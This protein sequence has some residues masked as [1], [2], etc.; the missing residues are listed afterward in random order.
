MIGKVELDIA[1]SQDFE[2]LIVEMDVGDQFRL[3]FSQEPGETEISVSIFNV[4]ASAY[5]REEAVYRKKD[6]RRMIPVKELL[7]L[8]DRGVQAL[9]S[10]PLPK[11]I[12]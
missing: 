7:E 12:P 3:I 1:S 6:E 5:D 10:Q 2:D 4:S 8:L 9:Q 11:A